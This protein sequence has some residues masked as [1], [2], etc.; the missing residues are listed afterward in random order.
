MAGK[1]DGLM[2]DDILGVAWFDEA[3]KR[4]DKQIMIDHRDYVKKEYMAWR[5]SEKGLERLVIAKTLKV[6]ETE[7]QS[8]IESGC[9]IAEAARA[10]LASDPKARVRYEK[11]LGHE[12]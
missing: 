5:L 12:R 6:T 2:D 9:S 11:A 8:L 7:A 1:G 4:F 3:S 10:R